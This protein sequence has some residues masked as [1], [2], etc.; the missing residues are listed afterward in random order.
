M[1]DVSSLKG[2]APGRTRGL[3]LHVID[4]HSGGLSGVDQLS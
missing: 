3:S 1:L 4:S 2:G